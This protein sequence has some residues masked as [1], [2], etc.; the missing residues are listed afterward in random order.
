[1]KTKRSK[2]KR[3]RETLDIMVS[4]TILCEI[5]EDIGMG[6]RAKTNIYRAQ[7][8]GVQED[9]VKGAKQQQLT[10]PAG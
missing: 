4:H 3:F 2:S 10:S 5:L 6:D 1:M 7:N 8:V 9:Y